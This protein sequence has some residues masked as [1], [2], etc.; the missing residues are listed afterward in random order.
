M[1]A[2]LALRPKRLPLL[3]P[4]LSSPLC[5]PPPCAVLAPR[6]WTADASVGRLVQT[7]L[8][9]CLDPREG[10]ASH[11]CQ[12]PGF[13]SYC[14][15]LGAHPAARPGLLS[16]SG[17]GSCG[18]PTHPTPPQQPQG[19]LNKRPADRLG[20]PELL[21]STACRS[22]PHRTSPHPAHCPPT[23]HHGGRRGC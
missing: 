18:P 1:L 17:P 20:W 14:W 11:A 10:S 16:L 5:Y 13:N 2:H 19:L 4:V 22:C 12:A 21:S 3:P 15:R 23:H 8:V 7:S 9:E 6:C